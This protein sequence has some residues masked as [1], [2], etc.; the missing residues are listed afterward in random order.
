MIWDFIGTAIFD[1]VNIRST[2]LIVVKLIVL[3]KNNTTHL[4][5]IKTPINSNQI[6]QN[7]ITTNI[8]PP[9]FNQRL[10]YYHYRKI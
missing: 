1:G 8:V 9:V 2:I 7:L 3:L 6:Y 4:K 10:V 5:A